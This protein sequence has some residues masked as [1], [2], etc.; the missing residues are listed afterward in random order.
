MARA[1]RLIVLFKRAEK[2]LIDDNL[3]MSTI[4][5]LRQARSDYCKEDALMGSST[6]LQP[7]APSFFHKIYYW[8][9]FR[10]ESEL[11]YIVLT[12]IVSLIPL[13]LLVYCLSVGAWS[14]LPIVT[15]TH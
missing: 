2:G 11:S 13:A 15:Y 12:M 9:L 14:R 5:L 8:F 7:S 3:D 1:L 4:S 10:F 6:V